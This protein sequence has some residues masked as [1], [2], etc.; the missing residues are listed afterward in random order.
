MMRLGRRHSG[1]RPSLLEVGT[2][3]GRIE[4]TTEG[5]V[6]DAVARRLGAEVQ[7]DPRLLVGGRE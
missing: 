6:R 4:A 2:L 5:L 3:G 7:V 1:E